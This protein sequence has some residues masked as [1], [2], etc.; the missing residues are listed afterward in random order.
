VTNF[1][2]AAVESLPTT[3]PTAGLSFSPG[4]ALAPIR[5]AIGFAGVGV[6]AGIET[7]QSVMR[8]LVLAEEIAFDIAEAEVNLAN[9]SD[10]RTQANRELL[11]GIEDLVGDEPI[12]RIAIFKE[13]EALRALSDRYRSVVTQGASLIDERAAF[14]KR[15]AAM[16]Q[17]NRY[18]DMTFRVH[19]NHALEVYHSMFDVA[20]RYTYLAAKAYDYETNFDPTD[21][22]SPSALFS[23]IIRSRTL[24]LVTDG[25]PQLG[26][27]GLADVLA[28]LHINHD[29]MKGQLGFNNPQYETGKMSLRTELFRILPSGST[30]PLGD[31][32]FPGGGQNSDVLWQ[33]TLQNARVDNL[34]AVPEYRYF[35]RPFASDIDANGNAAVEPGLVLRFSTRVLAGQNVFGHP[36]SGGDHAY[37]PSLFATKIRSVGVWF[38]DY[39]S[40]DV[41]N[42]LPQAP[43]VYLIPVGSDIMSIPNSPTPD[44]VRIWKVV[45][46]QIPVPLPSLTAQLDRSS[47]MP[48]LDS[49][50]GRIGSPRRHSSFRAY[51]DSGAEIDPEAIVYDS[52]LVGRSV[53]NTEWILI[54]PGL[55]LNS[56]PNEGLDRF[57]GQVTDIKLVFQTYGH[58]GN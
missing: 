35:A 56:D 22:G 1:R 24:G 51:H 25:E 49:L 8:L 10:E 6:V 31:N 52:R 44:K 9:A 11:K 26:E 46:Q 21:A 4:D 29:A 38:S 39:L 37:D 13:I 23:E 53:W 19:R 41:L 48:L 3:L 32:Q 12:L 58:S 47:F 14:N 7:A 27:A 18:Q 55:T 50:N 54:L 2:E 36:L 34:W 33:Q 28:R 5:G 40:D 15:V 43:R 30:Q 42:D 16:T 57:I 20:A 45:D 17:Q